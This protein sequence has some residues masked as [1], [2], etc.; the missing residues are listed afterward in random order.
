M[1]SYCDCGAVEHVHHIYVVKVANDDSDYQAFQIG[2][3]AL[4]EIESKLTLVEGIASATLA[5]LLE[6]AQGGGRIGQWKKRSL[7]KR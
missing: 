5:W 2:G 4:L 7:W 3:G 6:V 1:L